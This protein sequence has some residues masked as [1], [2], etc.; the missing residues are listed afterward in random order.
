M[1]RK[2]KILIVDD[3]PQNVRILSD[4]LK[5]A[6]FVVFEAGDGKAAIDMAEAHE[7]DL[8]LLDILMPVMDG[9]EVLERLKRNEKL[10]HIPVIVIS[11]VDELESVVRCIELGAE[12]YLTKPFNNVILN[13][14]VNACLNKK[15]WR[16]KEQQYQREIEAANEQLEE[17]VMK[18]TAELSDALHE[19]ESLKNRLQAEKVYLQ[20]EIKLDHN[21]DEIISR[22]RSFAA[23]SH[24]VEQV[25]ATDATVLLL[26]E[27]ATGKELMAR[28]IHDIGARQDRP[29]VKVNCASLPATL[30]ESELFGHEKG[31]F[32][33]AAERRHGRFEPA[34]GSSIS[35]GE[36]A[37][38]PL[39]LQA[40]LLRVLQEGEFE[41]LGGSNTIK[42]NVRLIAATNRNL[43]KEIAEGRFRED[44]YYRLNVFP[45]SCPPLRERKED[46][47][48]L[49]N[50]FV[51]KYSAKIGKNIETVS[52]NAMLR[53]KSYDWPGNV[54][55]LE[56]IIERAVIVSPGDRL[57]IGDWFQKTTP[58]PAAA[59]AAASAAVSAVT[60]EDVEREHIK[61][62]PEHTGWKIRGENGAAQ[63]LGLKPTTLES[64]MK[65]LGIERERG[66]S[67]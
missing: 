48:L 62:V 9:Y 29:L 34:N 3:N 26:G 51:K 13:A 4:R 39:E 64:R 28:A 57:E 65:K 21:F 14:R 19:V 53:L 67:R 20:Q 36:V 15:Q 41:R 33:G 58:G 1:E 37:E 63:L 43:E 66:A 24:S 32:T 11:A 52:G 56:N 35:L 6:G 54:R 59:S 61:K 49:V 30:I 10:R 12:D 40:K 2:Q 7:P 5:N 16:D 55:E 8:V 31:S 45:I 25:A 22:S 46:I 38:T 47:A 27:T 18:R 44:L 50:H 60:L 42:V 17:R 23:V